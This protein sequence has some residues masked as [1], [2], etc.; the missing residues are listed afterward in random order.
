MKYTLILVITILFFSLDVYS[1]NNSN[2]QKVKLNPV[3]Q[4]NEIL[5]PLYGKYFKDIYYAKLKISKIKSRVVENYENDLLNDKVY[6]K[7]LISLNN[8]LTNLAI[9]EDKRLHLLNKRN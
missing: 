4:E 3:E 7:Q 8:M 1:Q 9:I 6:N 2:N 5:D